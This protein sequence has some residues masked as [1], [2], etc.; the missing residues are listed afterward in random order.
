M[1][2][3][4]EKIYEIAEREGWAVSHTVCQGEISF[5]FSKL[6][7]AG[8]DFCFTRDVDYEDDEDYV[9][10]ELRDAVYRY[11]EN[12][13]V[14][15]ETYIWL[16]NTGHGRNG[17]PHDMKDLYEDMQACEDM[18]HDLWLALE[19]KEKPTKTEEKQYVF[20]VFECDA[21]H[22]YDSM[23]HM[24]TYLSLEEAVDAIM[25]H[26]EFDEEEDLDYIRE[27]LLDYRQTPETGDVNYEI[28]IVEIGTWNE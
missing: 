15:E 26:G 20:E 17:A 25:A 12:F 1:D 19:G 21:W 27:H 10:E 6:S 7:P 3:K 14:C 5:E 22:S 24:A 4:I 23:R 2:K 9:F 18:I 28:S 8:Q 16:D 11:W 13:D